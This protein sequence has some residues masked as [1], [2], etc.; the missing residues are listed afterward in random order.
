MKETQSTLNVSWILS[1][2]YLLSYH[3]QH[4]SHQL[5]TQVTTGRVPTEIAAVVVPF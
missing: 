3:G 4:T 5:V 2:K 1:S